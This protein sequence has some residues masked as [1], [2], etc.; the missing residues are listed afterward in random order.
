M[1]QLRRVAWALGWKLRILAGYQGY[2]LRGTP[3]HG[4]TYKSDLQVSTALKGEGIRQKGAGMHQET[5]ACS[6]QAPCNLG[7]VA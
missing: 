4:D 3:H 7:M 5:N 6:K 2:H 1:P